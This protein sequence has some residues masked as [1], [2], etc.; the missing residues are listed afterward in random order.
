MT[1]HRVRPEEKAAGLDPP[2]EGGVLDARLA[3]VLEDLRER[4][5]YRVRRV[6]DGAHAVRMRVDGRDCINFCS[7]DYLGLASDPRVAEAAR[8]GFARVGT[9]SSG[10]ALISGFNAEHRALEEELADF[11]GRPRALLFSTGWATNMGVLKA[12]LG[13]GDV[14]VADELNHASLIDGARASGAEYRR[15]AHA[16]LGACEHELQQSALDRRFALLVTDGVFSMDGDVADLPALA[17]LARRSSAALM[18]DDA[19]GFGVLGAR[20]RG[21]AELLGE[22]PEVL[23]ATLGKSLG[24]AGGFVAGSQVLIEYLIQRART[25]VFSTAPPPAMAAAARAALRIVRQEPEL[26]ARLHENIERFVGGA[27]QRGLPV[28]RRAVATP[29]QP[30]I[31]HDDARALVLSRELMSRGFWVAAIRP[32]TVPRGTARLRITLSAAHEPEQIDGLLDALAESL[33]ALP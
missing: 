11:L 22:E 26:R 33:R 7:N 13:R 16:D 15:I 28:E 27:Q 1:R 30:L 17:Q 19:H 12:L 8:A 2:Y 31:V 32:P 29:I 9:G 25:W 4:S 23:V 14:I 20:G 6:V 24:C 3:P 21:T 18:V 5:L 10:S